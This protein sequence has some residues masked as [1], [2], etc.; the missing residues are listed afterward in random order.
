[1][2][3]DDL[4]MAVIFIYIDGAKRLPSIDNKQSSFINPSHFSETW[5]GAKLKQKGAV[6][7][8]VKLV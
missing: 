1:L 7:G 5:V 2:I 3:I 4:R 6:Y 8:R